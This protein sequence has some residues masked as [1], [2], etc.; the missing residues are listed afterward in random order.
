MKIYLNIII[1]SRKNISFVSKIGK[2]CF[3]I[4]LFWKRIKMKIKYK[5][6]E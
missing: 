4:I 3:K 5:M 1:K 6:L 2:N